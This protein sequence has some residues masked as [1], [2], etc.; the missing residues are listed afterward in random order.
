V[1]QLPLP[2]RTGRAPAMVNTIQATKPEVRMGD[3]IAIRDRFYKAPFP[4]YFNLS[5]T[6]SFQSKIKLQNSKTLM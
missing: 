5:L 1:E 2:R 6:D 4:P 3:K